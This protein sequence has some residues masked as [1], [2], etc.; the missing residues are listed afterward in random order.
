MVAGDTPVI[1]AVGMIPGIIHP[2]MVLGGALAGVGEVFMPVGI[3]LGIIHLGML[4]T[5]AAIGAI[6][7]IIGEVVTGA[8][9]IIIARVM[10]LTTM[11]DPVRQTVTAFRQVT[12]HHLLPA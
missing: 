7:T 12:G 4:L 6:I 11:V 2:G 8:M 9:A 5:M 10:L 1:M 3:A